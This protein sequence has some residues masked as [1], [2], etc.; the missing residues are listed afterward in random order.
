[1]QCRLPRMQNST[2]DTVDVALSGNFSDAYAYATIDGTTYTTDNKVT[3]R[4]GTNV[5]VYC[6]GLSPAAQTQSTI[7]LNGQG[8][9]NGEG[10]ALAEYTFSATDNCNIVFSQ[11]RKENNGTY[12]YA[13]ITMP[14]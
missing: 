1:M 12:Y 3:V 9:A 6:G 5:T 11:V 14:A 13:T 7:S 8:V 4:K 10:D 2:M